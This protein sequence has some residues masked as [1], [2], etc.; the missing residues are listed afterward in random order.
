MLAAP[1]PFPL[2][3]SNSITTTTN[4]QHLPTTTT[5]TTHP[6][7]HPVDHLVGMVVKP[8]SL[9]SGRQSAPHLCKPCARFVSCSTSSP[10]VRRIKRKRNGMEQQ[11][12]LRRPA[13]QT[14]NNAHT[15]LYRNSKDRPDIY[16]SNQTDFILQ[17]IVVHPYV[18]KC[19]R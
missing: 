10:R 12:T 18:P 16:I 2:P 13:S 4:Q 15:T 19:P 9:H 14:G 8:R 6:P 7:T 11:N 1:P 17:Y 3:C 5:T